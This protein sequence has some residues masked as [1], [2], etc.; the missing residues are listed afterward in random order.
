MICN[1]RVGQRCDDFGQELLVDLSGW[2]RI[3]LGL[4][5]IPLTDLLIIFVVTAK[6]DHRRVMAKAFDVGDSFLLY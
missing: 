6:D 2:Q 5:D 1:H 4:V 3:R